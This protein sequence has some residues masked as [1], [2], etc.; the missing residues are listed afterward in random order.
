MAF[1]TCCALL[2]AQ[3]FLPPQRQKV[4]SACQTSV[5]CRDHKRPTCSASLLMCFSC[6]RF[7]CGPNA[8]KSAALAKQQKKRPRGNDRG[9]GKQA[10]DD[11]GDDEDS[12]ASD[13]GAPSL[14]APP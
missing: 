9:K 6:L 7:F 10:A 1:L 14:P 13:S 3:V 12:A 8:K 11:E 2:S 4:S 5:S